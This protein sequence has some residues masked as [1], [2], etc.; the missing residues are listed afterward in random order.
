MSAVPKTTGELRTFLA[1]MMLGVKNG[2]LSVDAASRITKLAGQ[3]NESMYA[4]VKVAKVRAEA[5]IVSP[6]FGNM[7]LGDTA[8]SGAS[9]Q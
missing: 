3:I 2:D 8:E 6:A 5:G 7:Q 4:E 1:T 9:A